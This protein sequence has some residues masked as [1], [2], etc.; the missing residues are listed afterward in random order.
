MQANKAE[1]SYK[2]A[3]Y[4]QL[5]IIGKC[6]STRGRLEIMNLLAQS[7]KTVDELAKLS[8]MTVANTSRHLQV[9]KKAHLVKS[10]KSKNF[11]IYELASPKVE[12]MFYLLR[13]V[14]EEEL[15][16]MKAIKSNF[17]SREG[18]HP[19]SLRQAKTKAQNPQTHVID[20][21]NANEFQHGH[22]PGAINIP[23]SDLEKNIAQFSRD[24]QII[25]YCRGH[26]CGLANQATH[27]LRQNGYKAYCLN[28]TYVDWQRASLSKASNSID[29]K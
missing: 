26:L 13:D 27:L 21:R 9:L 11:V 4:E 17:A 15:P 19:L 5:A 2:N 25:L 29:K 7:P 20:L 10:E 23:V 1:I 8:Q 28:E 12:Q 3:L 22:L 24:D 16:K 18:V 14:G 6:L